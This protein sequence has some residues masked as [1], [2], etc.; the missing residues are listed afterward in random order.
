[1]AQNRLLK[2]GTFLASEM[3]G[4]PRRSPT[5]IWFS[6]SLC[7]FEIGDFVDNVGTPGYALKVK[8]ALGNGRTQFP[9]VVLV[10]SKV[11]VHLIL[12]KSTVYTCI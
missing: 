4:T 10:D 6:A 5:P 3:Y 7:Y 12:I 2:G 1:M 9:A 11:R 8:F